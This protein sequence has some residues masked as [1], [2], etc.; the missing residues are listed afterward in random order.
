MKNITKPEINEYEE[1]DNVVRQ[2]WLSTYVNN[3]ITKEDILE[4]LKAGSTYLDTYV[5]KNES[6]KIVGMIKFVDKVDYIYLKQLY[7]LPEYQGQGLGSELLKKIPS[8]K[9]ICLQVSASNI[10]AINFYIKHG[11]KKL[12]KED[13]FL[14]NNKKVPVVFYCKEI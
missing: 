9:K 7:I 13:F 11:F 10:G 1:I 4:F 14:V 5:V 6:G 8:N 12:L 3:E 2:T